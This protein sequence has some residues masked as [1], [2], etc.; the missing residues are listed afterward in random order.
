M[1]Q[2]IEKELDSL[3]SD[4][5]EERCSNNAPTE[6][7]IKNVLAEL[8]TPEELAL[9]YCGSEHKALISGTYFLVYKRVLSVVLPIVAAVLAILTPLGFFIGGESAQTSIIIGAI[10]ISLPLMM[11]ATNI[12]ALIQTFAAI[13]IIFAVMEYKK[14]NLQGSDF[15]DLPEIPEARLKISPFWP[16]FGIV[17]S[18]S[19]TA[20][21]L[22]FPQI[23]GASI[24]FNWIP[25]FDTQIVRGLW[26]PIL[27][28]A[29]LEI[30]VE[31]V[32]LIEGRYTMRL[33]VVAVIS[34]ILS[35][36]CA[37]AIFGNNEI[38]NLQFF[39]QMEH[40]HMYFEALGGLFDNI[41]MRPNLVI[42]CIMLAIIF[43]ETL[44]VV[45]KAFQ[46]QRS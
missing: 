8:G 35:A 3:I 39:V 23:I 10:D 25:A 32:K 37:V 36:V 43:F 19:L 1:Q 38:M 44:D 41:I 30:G 33:A 11:I 6:Q 26:L 16:I 46:S 27:L 22:G 7:D 42:M 5:I 4:M 9:K 2:D 34:G 28:W 14:V 45:V 17:L 31:I 21:F 15:Y 24:N 29:I 40:Y 13:T 18:I 12:G 20:L